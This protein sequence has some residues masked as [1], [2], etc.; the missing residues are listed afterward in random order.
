MPNRQSKIKWVTKRGTDNSSIA[1]A[2]VITAADPRT[3]YTFLC[4]DTRLLNEFVWKSN[5]PLVLYS[6]IN[7]A[8]H[9]DVTNNNNTIGDVKPCPFCRELILSLS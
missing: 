4:L 3:A 5:C 7:T 8:R 2:K 9:N 6:G 1:K